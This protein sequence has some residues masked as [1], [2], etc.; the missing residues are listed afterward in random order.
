MSISIFGLLYTPP[1][2]PPMQIVQAVFDEAGDTGAS[3]ASSRYLVVAGIV[4]PSLEPLRRVVAQTR[5]SLGKKLRDIPELKAWH[6]PVQ[7]TAKLLKRLVRLDVQIYAAI[8]DKRAAQIPGDTEDWYRRVYA[9]AVRQ[10]VARHPQ[11]TVTMDKRYT[12]AVLRDKL[13]QFILSDAQRPETALSF[14]HDDSRREK[15]LQVADAVAWTMFQKYERE[16][17]TLHRL[18][19][20][21]VRG[22]VLLAK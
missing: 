22:E 17:E 20:G 15:A 2:M 18:I 7:V 1:Y 11:I 3:P 14:V 8:L 19:A 12:K 21:K 10:A 4:H 9:E 16:D 6:T 13:V 5:R